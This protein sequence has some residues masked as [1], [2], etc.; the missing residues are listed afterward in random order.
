MS[1]LEIAEEW[2]EARG[3]IVNTL[4][5]LNNAVNGNG[6]PGISKT[7]NDYIAYQKGRDTAME[8]AS[9]DRNRTLNIWLTIL[10]LLMSTLGILAGLEAHH[11]QI[12]TYVEPQQSKNAPADAGIP[13][14]P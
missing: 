12:V 13:Y 14:H 4:S 10:T 8:K 2:H 9:R 5:Q 7:L 11:D 3:A 6:Q 1:R